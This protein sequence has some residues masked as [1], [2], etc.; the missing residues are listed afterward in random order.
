M[1]LV[2]VSVGCSELIRVGW[3]FVR[4]GCRWLEL[5]RVSQS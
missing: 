1:E 2:G 5:V 3:S 4:V